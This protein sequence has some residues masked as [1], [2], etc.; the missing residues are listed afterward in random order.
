MT[1]LHGLGSI[2]FETPDPSSRLTFGTEVLGM[3]PARGL[4]GERLGSLMSL[5][6]GQGARGHRNFVSPFGVEF[7]TGELGPGH[8]L[9][10]VADVDANLG[11]YC[12][13]FGF[14]R[15]DFIPAGPGM[16]LLLLR[17]TK[18]HHT[19]GFVHGA[20]SSGVH[21]GPRRRGQVRRPARRRRHV[22]RTRGHRGEPW[23]HRGMNVQLPSEL[24]GGR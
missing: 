12:G 22:V 20:P 3:M 11:F 21:A 15:P 10:L 1:K 24:R 23:G 13:V 6:F 9:P 4:L 17:C 7:L 8:A 18:R 5:N 14:K 16:S 19:I 2:G